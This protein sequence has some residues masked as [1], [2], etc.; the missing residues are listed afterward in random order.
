[1]KLTGVE[2]VSAS[3]A[4]RLKRKNAYLES[5][6]EGMRRL[7]FS[8]FICF[9]TY[10]HAGAQVT[11]LS[12]FEFDRVAINYDTYKDPFLIFAHDDYI[13]ITQNESQNYQSK[14]YQISSGETYDLDFAVTR[15]TEVGNDRVYS[16]VFDGNFGNSV[17]F[18]PP[19]GFTNYPSYPP[20]NVFDYEGT[21]YALEQGKL[22]QVN[23]GPYEVT[24]VADL[25]NFGYGSYQEMVIENDTAYLAMSRALVKVSLITGQVSELHRQFI[26]NLSLELIPNSFLNGAHLFISADADEITYY[27]LG[28]NG[29]FREINVDFS[30]P[31][32]SLY[33]SFSG[34]MQ[35]DKSNIASNGN[36]TYLH[37]RFNGDGD[38]FWEQYFIRFD[39]SLAGGTAET[40]GEFVRYKYEVDIGGAAVWALNGGNTPVVNGLMGPAGNEP[41][42]LAGDTL[43]ALADLIPGGEGSVDYEIYSDRSNSR[44]FDNPQTWDD[45]ALFV[46]RH[47]NHG[48]ELT[49]S[50]GTPEGT[51]MLTDLIPGADGLLHAQFLELSADSLLVFVQRDDLSY[52]LYLLGENLPEPFKPEMP[53]EVATSTLALYPENHQSFQEHTNAKLNLRQDEDGALYFLSPRLFWGYAFGDSG[54]DPD[55]LNPFQL[56]DDCMRLQKI[57]PQTGE[58]IFSKN[59]ATRPLGGS[60]FED[61]AGLI[62]HSDGTLKVLQNKRGGFVNEN[63]SIPPSNIGDLTITTF[64]KNGDFLNVVTSNTDFDHSRILNFETFSNGVMIALTKSETYFKT[65]FYL[66]TFSPDGELIEEVDISELTSEDP[67]LW[68]SPDGASVN[69]ALF[70]AS[71]D[72]SSKAVL[73]KKYSSSLT[74][75]DLGSYCYSGTLLAPQVVTY[76]NGDKL[77]TGAIN[78]E[79]FGGIV[80]AGYNLGNEDENYAAFAFKRSASNPNLSPIEIL[81]NRVTHFYNGLDYEGERHLQFIEAKEKGYELVTAQLDTDL[82]IA[83]SFRQ[84]MVIRDRA[85]PVK[86]SSGVHEDRWWQFTAAGKYNEI[87]V[88]TL[89]SPPLYRLNRSEIWGI[90]RTWPFEKITNINRPDAA[91]KI[92]FSVF[93]NPSMGSFYLQPLAEGVLPYSTYEV[94]DVTGKLVIEGNM[95]STMSTIE[96][97]LPGN[98]LTGVYQL[99][100]IGSDRSENHRIV[101]I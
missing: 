92:L 66:V 11:H 38:R 79:L 76:T 3:F 40:I 31:F 101:V 60:R 95:P 63:F 84:R 48:V 97:S 55:F 72:C 47:I 37:C 16:V 42:G 93:P 27:E 49:V 75:T 89:I 29:L 24:T 33:A 57:D 5:Q 10:L 34:S 43:V 88:D 64:S 58:I 1:M 13:F 4:L 98:A 18:L 52:G 91:G 35:F 50:D 69:L 65:S 90:H 26:D 51:G 87:W 12:D 81:S 61:G 78:G 39:R 71:T 41:Y 7:F 21:G 15:Q 22:K 46:A 73:F 28:F 56:N 8:V 70:T 23:L 45:K 99:R 77:Y 94:Y 6:N 17:Q 86:M 68:L 9:L 2:T 14:V 53:D 30:V 32:F 82:K 74:D 83:D 62:I 67:N 19:D 25:S 36:Y 85:M 20:F 54:P 80:N 96:I 44:S 59:F 100:L